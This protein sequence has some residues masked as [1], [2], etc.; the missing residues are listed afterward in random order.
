M[1]GL[2]E[3]ALL[4]TLI[5]RPLKGARWTRWVSVDGSPI[6]R[7][8]FKWGTTQ[9][10]FREGSWSGIAKKDGFQVWW[11]QQRLFS[12]FLLNQ[13]CKNHVEVLDPIGVC[14]DSALVKV[15]TS[16]KDAF[17]VLLP[18]WLKS[19]CN[20]WGQLSKRQASLFLRMCPSGTDFFKELL[21]Q[22]FEGFPPGKK[23]FLQRDISNDLAS[24]I[25]AKKLFESKISGSKER[26][27]LQ[28]APFWRSSD[29]NRGE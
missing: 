9:K 17:V 8:V 14:S 3:S 27:L 12:C 28:R 24:E 4:E 26:F 19:Q 15:R 18:S 6:F 7:I 2:N 29:L 23:F 25:V 10:L 1:F 21:H 13:K 5:T 16:N 11:Y 22:V 20:Q